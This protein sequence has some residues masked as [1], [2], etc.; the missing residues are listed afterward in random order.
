MET[1]SGLINLGHSCYLNAAL[2]CIYSCLIV[3]GGLSLRGSANSELLC[4]VL[5]LFS[6]MNTNS[7]RPKD[8]SRIY[9]CLPEDLCTPGI[10]QDPSEFFIR[11]FDDLQEENPFR[12][13]FTFSHIISRKHAQSCKG[14]HG[15][16]V[17]SAEDSYAVNLP[18]FDSSFYCNE[19][20]CLIDDEKSSDITVRDALNHG[21]RFK[22]PSYYHS[23]TSNGNSNRA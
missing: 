15:Q 20:L 9:A 1:P 6:I 16:E 3:V 21:S 22:T 13:L 14:N 11:L 4:E 2:Q 12:L 23:V 5:S 17:Q 10:H 7:R 19:T 18:T 8:T